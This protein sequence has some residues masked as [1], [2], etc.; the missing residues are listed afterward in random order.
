VGRPYNRDHADPGTDLIQSADSSFI[1]RYYYSMK[2][3]RSLSGYLGAVAIVALASLV[4]AAVR[5]YLAPTNMVMIFLLAVVFAAARLGLRPAIMTAFLSVLAFDV[6]FVPPHLSLRVSDTEYLVT[7]FALF[8]VGVVISS[9]V[10]RVRETVEQ[11][12]HQEARTSSLYYLTRDMA[13]AFDEPAIVDALSRAALRDLESRLTIVLNR[14]GV[15][16]TVSSSDGVPL[17]D[18][19]ST[20][21]RWVIQSGRRA[22]AGTAAFPD[23][24]YLSIPIK[25]GVNVI[26][27]MILVESGRSLND[28]LELIDAFAGLAGMA[29]ERVHLS[30]QAEEARVLKEKNHLEQALL[31]SISH[32]LRTPLV[33]I[34]GVLDSLLDDDRRFDL[35][36]RRDMIV[37][38]AE[39]AGRLNRFVGSLLDMT[40]LE[41]GAL[42]PRFAP[43]EVDEIIGCAVGAV[44]QRVGN[45]TIV[46]SVPT[47]RP[48]VPADLALLTQALVNLL[49]NALKHSPP[50][51]DIEMSAR[52]D[53]SRVIISVEDSGPGVPC[54]EEERIFDKFHRIK[55]P[56]RTGGT[57]L[58]LSIAKG[59]IMAHKGSITASNRPQGGLLIE[60]ILPAEINKEENKE[61]Q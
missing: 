38:A 55:I 30:S 9:L 17:D 29:F 36:Q 11:V 61:N 48:L 42:S 49:D 8:V 10:A 23:V 3:F 53:G 28:N 37:A 21:I 16:E 1:Q 15:P 18:M 27:V 47:D 44:E 51:A 4:C 25:S 46:T 45:H 2:F 6:F 26:G 20:I 43:C 19:N 5:S 34:S 7:F 50:E 59:I 22:G 31:N 13:V 57:G 41:A 60:V 35:H 54:G 39:E 24:P 52:L 14:G 56:E 58:G 12:R 33:T 32:D 40:R